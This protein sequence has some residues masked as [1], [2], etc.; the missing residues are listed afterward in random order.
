[1]FE[2]LVADSD[3]AEGNVKFDK[4]FAQIYSDKISNHPKCEELSKVK[5]FSMLGVETLLMA[6]AFAI[7][8]RNAIVEIG[9][10]I[11]GSTVAL[12]TGVFASTTKKIISIDAGGEYLNHPHIPSANIHI[13]W[14]KNVDNY[15]ICDIATLIKGR[16]RFPQIVEQ[17]VSQLNGQK[18]GVLFIDAD[19]HLFQNFV[20]LIP[21]LDEECLLIFDDYTNLSEGLDSGKNRAVRQVIDKA[22]EVGAFDEYCVLKW[23]TWFGRLGKTFTEN[24]HKLF[25]FEVG[26]GFKARW[27][28]LEQGDI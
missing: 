21:H 5:K 10:Y 18:I 27:Q 8:T 2:H 28:L 13:D 12:G 26:L 16:A 24:W 9:P 17:I 23:G 14:Q 1:M 7:E 22:T 3:L 20:E 25:D 19:G 15:G 6:R 11:G 4:E